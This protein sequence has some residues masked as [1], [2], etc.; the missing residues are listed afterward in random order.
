MHLVDL[1]K[2]PVLKITEKGVRTTEGEVEAEA[3]VYVIGYDACTGPLTR[4]DI[5]GK[6][7]VSL[8]E[9]WT[10]GMRTHLGVANS[11]FPNY[12]TTT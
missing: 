2:R 9:K 8:R 11:G 4:V 10:D 3:I 7:S 12:F 6:D 5:G 1:N